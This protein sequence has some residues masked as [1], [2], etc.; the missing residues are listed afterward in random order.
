MKELAG[1]FHTR[2]VKSWLTEDGVL[3]LPHGRRL[4]QEAPDSIRPMIDLVL[5][6]ANR[7][8]R[9][10]LL[11]LMTEATYGNTSQSGVLG[12]AAEYLVAQRGLPPSRVQCG[13]DRDLL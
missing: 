4:K 8:L 2:A 9:A 13:V 3:C 6:R 1:S 12:K 5:A 10:A 7:E 11:Q